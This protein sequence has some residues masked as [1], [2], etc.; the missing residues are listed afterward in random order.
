M[1]SS[2]IR[3]AFD[4]DRFCGFASLTYERVALHWLVVPYD[5]DRFALCCV[6]G[7]LAVYQRI[8]TQGGGDLTSLLDGSSFPVL[9]DC[10][11]LRLALRTTEIVL[12]VDS[13]QMLC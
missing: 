1:Q 2:N 8:A 3:L 5:E 12:C 9:G 7:E 4:R 13:I 11:T 6:S 10:A